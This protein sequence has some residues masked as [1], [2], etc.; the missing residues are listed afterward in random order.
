MKILLRA[1]RPPHD[2]SSN[3]AALAWGRGGTFSSNTGNVLTSDSIYTTL[4]VPGTEIIC[5]SYVPENRSLTSQEIATINETYDAYI[6]PLAN[7]L[8]P[9]FAK[10]LRNLTDFI[11]KLTIP[12]VVTGMGANVP[13]IH[14]GRVQDSVS[15]ASYEFIRAVLDHSSCIGVRGEVTRHALLKLGFNDSDIVVIGTPALAAE[16]PKPVTKGFWNAGAMNLAITLN[17][18]IEGI[19]KF[20]SLNEE[21][22]PKLTSILQS[23]DAAN[24]LLWG[25]PATRFPAGIPST[26]YDKAYTENR[27]KLFTNSRVWK[28]Y[29]RTQSFVFGPRIL[30]AAAALSIGTPAFVLTFDTRTVEISEYHDIPHADFQTVL[31]SKNCIAEK[32]FDA[33]DYSN[34]NKRSSEIHETFLSFLEKNNLQHIFMPGMRNQAYEEKLYRVPLAPVVEPISINNS[35]ALAERLNWLRQDRDFDHWRPF[36]SYQPEFELFTEKTNSPQRLI[37]Q[38]KKENQ[39]LTNQLSAHRTEILALAKR[40]TELQRTSDDLLG[41]VRGLNKNIL[42]RSIRKLKRILVRR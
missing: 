39:T 31:Q 7:A 28:G 15:E 41:E 4:K 5:D 12:V 30:G 2:E 13:D 20:Y 42:I 10:Q 14:E 1:G 27:A 38:L 26:V 19:G 24:L 36:S 32:L 11:E 40:V 9:G 16:T 3:E 33:A 21:H 37:T 22:Y 25:K 23:V 8:R 35:S 34:F 18:D 17:P 6:V 29:L